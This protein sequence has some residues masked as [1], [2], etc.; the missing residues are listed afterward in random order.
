[1]LLV[2]DLYQ[3]ESELFHFLVSN[4]SKKRTKKNWEYLD[5]NSK[6]LGE[7]IYKVISRR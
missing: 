6:E 3:P 7:L 5:F 2:L 1:M 4:L